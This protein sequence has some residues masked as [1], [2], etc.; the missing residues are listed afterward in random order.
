MGITLHIIFFFFLVVCNVFS[1]NLIS[2]ILVSMYLSVFL[3]G[4][5]LHGILCS[6]WTWLAIFFPMLGKF[7]TIISL[8]IFLVPCF[9]FSSYRTLI[10]QTLV[11]LVLSEF[12][13]TFFNSFH[14]FFLY[15][16]F[17]LNATKKI[18]IINH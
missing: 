10:T 16:F 18:D 2:V 17:L 9:F 13:E 8:D 11:H 3:L 6:S 4:F 7:F 14:S 5:I 1:L 15:S 12:P